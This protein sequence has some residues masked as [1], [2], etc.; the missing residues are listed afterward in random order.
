[1][2][3]RWTENTDKKRND[4]ND[5]IDSCPACGR[6][7][8]AD[9]TAKI[10]KIKDFALILLINVISL[11]RFHFLSQPSQASVLLGVYCVSEQQ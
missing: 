5:I 7:Y 6:P 10:N 3:F 9:K 11:A 4:S 1:M 2:E 8:I